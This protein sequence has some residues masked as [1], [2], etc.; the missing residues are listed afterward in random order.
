MLKGG[1]ILTS[2]SYG[3]VARFDGNLA[4]QLSESE[5][6][7]DVESEDSSQADD[8]T[9]RAAPSLS[10]QMSRNSQV[11]SVEGKSERET[12]KGTFI[13]SMLPFAVTTGISFS[14]QRRAS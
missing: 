12:K 3:D 10:K 8:E 4:R 7:D 2:G 9:A 11:P 6:M 14:I 1:A 13:V 5:S